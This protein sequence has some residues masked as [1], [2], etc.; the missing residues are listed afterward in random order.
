MTYDLREKQTN[1]QKRQGTGVSMSEPQPVR[2]GGY[3]PLDHPRNFPVS[4]TRTDATITGKATFFDF[5]KRITTDTDLLARGERL[6]HLRTNHKD[7]YK[8]EKLWQ[9]ALLIGR[10][11]KRRKNANIEKY[12]PVLGYDLD[13]FQTWEQVTAAKEILKTLPYVFCIFPSSSFLGLRFLIWTNSTIKNHKDFYQQIAADIQKKTGIQTKE[14]IKKNTPKA[15]HQKALK[16]TVHI[17][18]TSDLSRQWFFSGMDAKHIY[19]NLDATTFYC[20]PTPK[21]EPKPNKWKKSNN[22]GIN[23]NADFTNTQKIENLIGQIR[24]AKKDITSDRAEWVQIGASLKNEFGESGREYFHAVSQFYDGYSPRVTDQNFNSFGGSSTIGS[25]IHI[26]K[27]YGF[28]IDW[29]QLY[30]ENPAISQAHSKRKPTT[31]KQVRPAKPIETFT[32][33]GKQRFSHICKEVLSLLLKHGKIQLDGGL[34]LGKNWGVVNILADGLFKVNGCQSVVILPNNAK[35]E[36]DGKQ[37]GVNIVTAEQIKQMGENKDVILGSKII[38]CNQNSFKFIAD[39]FKSKGKKINVFCDESHLL[40]KSAYKKEVVPQMWD[41]I[42]Y[43]SETCMCFSGTPTPYLLELGFK[44]ISA[45]NKDRRK[46]KFRFRNRL[47]SLE[48]TAI[49]HILKTDYSDNK[50]NIVQLQDKTRIKLIIKILIEQYGF[51]KDEIVTLV[52]D[53]AVKE[54]KDY[55]RFRDAKKGQ[56]SFGEKVKVVL[57]TS[58]INEGI[59]I[60]SSRIIDFV[61]IENHQYF[62]KDNSVQ[63]PDR[64]RTP[65]ISTCYSYH[66]EEKD[67]TYDVSYDRQTDFRCKLR[68]AEKM[69]KGFNIVFED[70]KKDSYYLPEV[71]T[72][73]DNNA[74]YI[75]NSDFWGC[76]RVNKIAFMQDCETRFIKSLSTSQGIERIKKEFPHVDVTDERETFSFDEN[77]E[78]AQIVKDFADAE[79]EE[80]KKSYVLIQKLFRAD[81]DVF[82]HAI[83]KATRN[84]KIRAKI[85]NIVSKKEDAIKLISDNDKLFAERINECENFI[86]KYYE[87][88][89]LHFDDEQTLSLLFRIDGDIIK[90]QKYSFRINQL[91]VQIGDYIFKKQNSTID[92]KQMKKLFLTQKKDIAERSRLRDKLVKAFTKANNVLSIRDASQI[93]IDYYSHNRRRRVFITEKKATRLIRSL[94]NV[95]RKIPDNVPFYVFNGEIG[96]KDIFDNI[97]GSEK[98]VKM[99]TE[100][101]D[102][103]LIIS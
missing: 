30:Q 68:H 4:F 62:D 8:V 14:T 89:S 83:K 23:Q 19:L 60:Y 73:F 86:K 97:L 59:D 32:L 45:H 3:L 7:R 18:S 88:L 41:A 61:N 87:L 58:F 17:D 21:P 102:N 99:Y 10:F 38:F 26:C 48:Q 49:K 84:N 44:R 6:R 100:K 1:E 34:G 81:K 37:Y 98:G 80:K 65:N 43:I 40:A 28:T 42:E 77:E 54:S 47:K 85:K 12:V 20:T 33:S 46:I 76:L 52:S 31:T 72:Q 15:D 24:S 35:V 9:D 94:V 67:R 92:T 82:L 66:P 91:R 63:F 56:E 16:S 75:Y 69:V 51:K 22:L 50:I 27:E 29:K 57:V 55:I 78:D 74:R 90:N 53:P 64:H 13:G 5:L 70:A 79:K 95:E 101:I 103:S 36:K 11:K 96:F 39:H 2:V 71:R 93:V 25:F